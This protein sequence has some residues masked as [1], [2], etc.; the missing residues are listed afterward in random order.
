MIE[1]S[2]YV[3]EQTKTGVQSRVLQPN[4]FFFLLL[5]TRDTK[6]VKNYQTTFF[7]ILL[8]VDGDFCDINDD[9]CYL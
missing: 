4:Y 5:H 7:D 3:H 1:K 6:E 9:F 8:C 2:T